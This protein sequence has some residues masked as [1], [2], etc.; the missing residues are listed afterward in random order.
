MEVKLNI[1]YEQLIAIISQLP[2]DEVSKLKTE[3]ERI[4]SEGNSG[5][6]DS[7]ERLIVDGPVMSDERYQAFK[8]NRER[9]NARRE[10]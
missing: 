5:A 2:T 1:R 9:F 10:N 4:L 6:D 3:I 8:E 7:L